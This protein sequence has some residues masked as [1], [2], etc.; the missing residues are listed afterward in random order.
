MLRRV[1]NRGEE[2]QR[3]TEEGG[4]LCA[5][6]HSTRR[7]RVRSRSVNHHPEDGGGVP[8]ETPGFTW[9]A[10]E[11]R[12]LLFPTSHWGGALYTRDTVKDGQPGF[13]YVSRDECH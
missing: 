12:D 4:E 10:W 8:L 9:K 6:P 2:R 7:A 13:K 5:P 11:G 3:G 1:R